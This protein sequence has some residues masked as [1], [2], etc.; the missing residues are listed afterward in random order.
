MMTGD[1]KS[2]SENGMRSEG[3]RRTWMPITPRSLRRK[4]RSHNKNSPGMVQKEMPVQAHNH[5]HPDTMHNV[6]H[7]PHLQDLLMVR[8]QSHNLD[9]RQHP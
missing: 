2:T 6:P 5:N 3:K 7:H 4:C 8:A 9:H 1:V